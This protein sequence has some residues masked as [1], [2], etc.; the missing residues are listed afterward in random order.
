MELSREA[1]WQNETAGGYHKGVPAW[2]DPETEQPLPAGSV[3]GEQLPMGELSQTTEMQ[4]STGPGRVTIADLSDTLGNPL[5]K[6]T[7]NQLVEAALRLVANRSV[8]GSGVTALYETIG[9]TGRV[10]SPQKW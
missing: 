6:K 7:L 4:A 9:D 2:R 5:V 8:P 10:S 1:T 3:P